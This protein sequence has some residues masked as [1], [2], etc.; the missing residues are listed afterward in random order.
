[1]SFKENARAQKS[2]YSTQQAGQSRVREGRVGGLCRLIARE[3]SLARWTALPGALLGV[4]VRG[5][6]RV[7]P[8]IA[9][10]VGVQGG[11]KEK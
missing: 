8:Q 2:I 6:Q 11:R 4:R 5:W 10:R 7:L 1:M 9:H 3:C